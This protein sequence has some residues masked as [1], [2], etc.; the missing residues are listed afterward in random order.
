MND[1]VGIHGISWHDQSRSNE[2]VW[3]GGMANSTHRPQSNNLWED[4]YDDGYVDY[5]HEI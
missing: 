3:P 4:A 5:V 2:P 1:Q